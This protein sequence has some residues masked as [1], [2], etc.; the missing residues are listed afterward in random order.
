M[1]RAAGPSDDVAKVARTVA[2]LARVTERTAEGLDD[3]AGDVA[4]VR[5]ALT[6]QDRRLANLETATAD[7]RGARG[8]EVAAWIRLRAELAALLTRAVRGVGLVAGHVR[9]YPARALLTA[10][11][12]SGALGWEHGRETLAG[13]AR[14]LS[15][16]LGGSP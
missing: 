12:V 11:A 9:K 1:T 13:L 14:A 15:A 6:A 3:V 7:L 4:E 8:R 16:A 10:A 2:K 5:A